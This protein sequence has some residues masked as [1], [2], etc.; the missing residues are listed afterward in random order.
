MKFYE[1]DEALKEAIAAGDK[2]VRLKIELQ[3]AGHFESIFEQDIIEANFYGLK[4]ASG[5][6][7]SRGDILINNEKFGIRNEGIKVGS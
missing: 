7:S 4:E 2:A 3:I 5:G 1:I 6:T